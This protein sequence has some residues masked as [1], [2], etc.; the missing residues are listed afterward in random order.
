M[1]NI[2]FTQNI[3][4]EI[5]HLIDDWGNQ[6]C[7]AL[8]DTNSYQYC[9]NYFEDCGLNEEHI[10]TLP[11]G[12]AHKTLESV[13][14]IWNFLI[15]R[16]ANRHSLLINVGGGTITD[17]GGFAASCFKRGIAFV[18]I[19]TTL[20]AQVDASI[21]GKTGINYMGLKNE[22]GC[23]SQ[24]YKVF[25]DNRFL[26]SLN[27]NELLSGYGEMLKHGLLSSTE[28][29]DELLQMDLE[30]IDKKR[31]LEL[32]RE[33]VEIKAV[34]VEEDPCE[35]GIRKA[36]NFG[37]T[38]AHALESAA[39]AAKSPISHGMA[40]ALGIVVELK[41]SELLMHFPQGWYHKIKDHILHSYP[42]YP[43][44]V[45]QE[46]LYHY[47]LHD[48]KNDERGINFTLLMKPGEFY[49]DNFCTHDQI[50]TALNEI[51]YE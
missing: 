3:T 27:R 26:K 19:P 42:A 34:I 35:E 12:E 14:L 39:L 22:I 37:H 31:Y 11:A 38:V 24:P 41:L 2:K 17:I 32:I 36:L 5:K 45:D 48:K 10:L 13:S 4:N 33:S 1:S 20:L 30:H 44:P 23:F 47:M 21:G 28:E 9:F 29:L 18:N 16:G 7:F 43:I 40:V 15:T 49:I 50:I 51:I 46:S 8:F 6:R 25:I